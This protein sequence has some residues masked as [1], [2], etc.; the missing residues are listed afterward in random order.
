MT[1]M[2]ELLANI[3]IY[4]VTSTGGTSARYY[5]ENCHLGSNAIAVFKA[6][7][8]V[9]TG[10]IIFPN[11]FTLRPRSIT[12]NRYRNLVSYSLMPKGGH[13]AAM[14]EPELLARD[15]CQFVEK[16]RSGQ[17]SRKKNEL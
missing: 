5:A 8:Y 3:M 17:S 12:E 16:V 1:T 4:W 6:P 13:F 14:E 9:P 15:L 7:V 11:E 10:V 2:D